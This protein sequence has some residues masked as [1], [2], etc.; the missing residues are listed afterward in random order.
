M[1]TLITLLNNFSSSI[2]HSRIHLTWNR[3]CPTVS[4]RGLI[5]NGF[6][7]SIHEVHIEIITKRFHSP[8]SLAPLGA[9]MSSSF[10]KNFTGC[11]DCKH[12]WHLE[13]LTKVYIRIKLK[14]A[15]RIIQ[16]KLTWE[17]VV[18][19]KH[20]INHQHYPHASQCYYKHQTTISRR[21][22]CYYHFYQ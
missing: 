5:W 7:N 21:S 14:F 19:A 22:L 10:G 2:R 12:A 16:P 3:F 11:F 6:R 20:S 13:L 4:I 17:K 18:N 15:S 1:F 9:S 8:L